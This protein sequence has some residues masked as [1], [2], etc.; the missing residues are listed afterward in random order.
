MNKSQIQ[1]NR[2]YTQVQGREG[3]RE[4]IEEE[5]SSTLFV[6]FQSIRTKIKQP[7]VHHLESFK[8]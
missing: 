7:K 2:P 5:T 4:Q 8:I 6:S 1:K 3:G